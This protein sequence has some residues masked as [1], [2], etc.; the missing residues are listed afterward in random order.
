MNTPQF[1]LQ[2]LFF[3]VNSFTVAFIVWF[4][5]RMHNRMNSKLDLYLDYMRHVSNRNDIVYINQLG[6][7][8]SR[9]MREERYEEAKDKLYK[10]GIEPCPIRENNHS[11]NS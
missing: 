9:L 10:A 5:C 3:I 1:I 8:K 7:L 4:V 6:S 11:R 2:T